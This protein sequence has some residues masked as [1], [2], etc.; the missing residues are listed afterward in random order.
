[1][2]DAIVVGQ[3]RQIYNSKLNQRYCVEITEDNIDSILRYDGQV[4]SDND[5]IFGDV[6]AQDMQNLGEN[7]RDS[8]YYATISFEEQN[9][10]LVPTVTQT[11][12]YDGGRR[13]RK[14]KKSKTSKKRPTARRRRSSKARKARKSRKSRQSRATRRK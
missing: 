1:M 7:G 10:L 14:V 13:S 4:K 11:N 12:Q 6:C 9:G 5:W 3:K 8:Y 2:T